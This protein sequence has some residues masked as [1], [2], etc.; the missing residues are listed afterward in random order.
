M[1]SV[2]ASLARVVSSAKPELNVR[3][4]KLSFEEFSAMVANTDIVK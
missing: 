4:G 2:H 1:S 3:D